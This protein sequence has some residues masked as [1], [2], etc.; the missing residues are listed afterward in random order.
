MTEKIGFWEEG[1]NFLVEQVGKFMKRE[2]NEAADQQGGL[3]ASTPN[4]MARVDGGGLVFDV[5]PTANGDFKDKSV[6]VGATGFFGW[7]EVGGSTSC[8]IGITGNQTYN[9]SFDTGF[10]SHSRG[11]SFEMSYRESFRDGRGYLNIG[12]SHGQNAFY[13]ESVHGEYEDGNNSTTFSITLSQN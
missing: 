13:G 2:I 5:T 1:G 10:D 12:L 8:R 3:N 6:E 9:R 4:S 7:S 11:Y